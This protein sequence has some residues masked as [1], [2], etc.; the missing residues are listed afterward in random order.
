MTHAVSVREV[1]VDQF[2]LVWALTD[3][4]LAALTEDDFGWPPS[5]LVWTVRQDADGVWRPDWADVE[6]DPI[7]V[8][9]VA[10]LT[11]QMQWYWSTALAHVQQQ[12]PPERRDVTWP[13]TGLAAIAALRDLS[14]QWRDALVALDDGDLTRPSAFPW[15]VD[16]GRTVAHMVAWLN[17]ELAK[18]AAEIG[19]IRMIRATTR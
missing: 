1:L 17:V 7:P 4:H 13:G 9:T 2:D 16:V 19:Q 10:W 18:N 14:A 3:L 8:P 15:P 12:D 6:P 11:W 5:D